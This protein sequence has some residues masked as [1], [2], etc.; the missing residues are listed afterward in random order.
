MGMIRKCFKSNCFVICNGDCLNCERSYFGNKIEETAQ[1][2]EK[3]L[4]SPVTSEQVQSVGCKFCLSD[5][6]KVCGFQD[7]LR[8][9]DLNFVLNVEES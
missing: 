5:K 1:L 9:R 3:D 2:T 4:E 8:T 7:H 6:I